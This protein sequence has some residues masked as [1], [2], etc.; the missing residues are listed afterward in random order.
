MELSTAWLWLWA[1]TITLTLQTSRYFSNIQTA[2]PCLT[3]SRFKDTLGVAFHRARKTDTVSQSV[4]AI[5]DLGV[6]PHDF[7][8]LHILNA[9]EKQV[10]RPGFAA[11]WPCRSTLQMSRKSSRIRPGGATLAPCHGA[12]ILRTC[13]GSLL[14]CRCIWRVTCRRLK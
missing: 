12:M 8:R 3:R 11:T 5:A 6:D 1:V 10:P 7:K 4:S 14:R 2:K 13:T 9:T